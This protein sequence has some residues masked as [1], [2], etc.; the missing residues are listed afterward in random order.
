MRP[1]RKLWLVVAAI[2]AALLFWVGLDLF[3]P[4]R[5]DIRR[6]DPNEVAHLD[7]V[8]WRSYY[9]RN[10]RELFFQLAELMRRQFHFPLLRSNEVAAYA[11]KAAFIFK[12]G[13]NRAEYEQALPELVKYFQAIRD[14][15]AEPFDVPRAAKLE[16]EWW[17][18]HRE[19]ENHADG[20][21]PRALA[22][23]AAELYQVPPDKLMEYGRYRAEAM[24]IRDAKAAAGGLTE[25]DWRHIETDLQSSWQSLW[26]AIQP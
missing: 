1:K 5:A 24:K 22:E 2:I 20:D 17:I 12:D 25:D 21:L 8:M 15:S 6:F 14:I 18:V 10:P 7:S 26:K 13:H 16:L 23:A 4:R 9:E 11:A 19:R 3:G